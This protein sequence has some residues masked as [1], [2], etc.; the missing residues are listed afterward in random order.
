MGVESGIQFQVHPDRTVEYL[1]RRYHGVKLV[2]G[3]WYFRE[4]NV[5]KPFPL[6]HEIRA[7]SPEASTARP[8]Q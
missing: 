5:Y 6:Q 8:G 2:N 3:I 7:L 1:G 4:G